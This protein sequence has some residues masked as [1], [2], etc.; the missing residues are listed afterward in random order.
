MIQNDSSVNSYGE[1]VQLLKEIYAHLAQ[2]HFHELEV[3]KRGTLSIADYNRGFEKLQNKAKLLLN[4]Y[5]E[6]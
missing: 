6:I 3:Y 5:L 2:R 4:P 1:A